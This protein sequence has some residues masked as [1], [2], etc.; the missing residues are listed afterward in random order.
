MARRHAWA[1]FAPPLL[2][3]TLTACTGFGSTTTAQ[4]SL[5]CDGVLA[6]VLERIRTG[7]TAGTINSEM[8]WL[9]SN[10]PAEYDIAVD[11]ASGDRAPSTSE[12]RIAWNDA[13]DHVGTTQE[14][15]GPLA[16]MGNSTDDVFLNLGLDYPDPGRFQIVLWD[17]GGVEPLAPGTTLC[18]TGLI[19]LYEGV[20]QIETEVVGSVQVV[21]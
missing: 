10:C 16:G 8:D 13:I 7:D 15:C 11:H 1:S 9:S 21:E 6:Q 17:V 3:L 2:V 4:P 20:A 19:T 5:S 18:I 14:V 12:G